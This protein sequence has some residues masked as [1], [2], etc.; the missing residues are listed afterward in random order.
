MGD[1][2][3]IFS[4]QHRHF[5][6]ECDNNKKEEHVM[7]HLEQNF[8]VVKLWEL[9]MRDIWKTENEFS[10]SLI[11]HKVIIQPWHA[12]FITCLWFETPVK[13]SYNIKPLSLIK[14]QTLVNSFL[15]L[16]IN[17]TNLPTTCEKFVSTSIFFYS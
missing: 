6:A 10:N 1:Q 7:G 9:S 8:R 14:H 4:S 17:T 2:Y 15:D 11:I 3:S 16:N 12:N 13:V 5:Q